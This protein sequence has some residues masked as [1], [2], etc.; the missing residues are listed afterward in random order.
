MVK[1]KLKI[2]SL[3]ALFSSTVMGEVLTLQNAEQKAVENAFEIRATEKEMESKEWEQ[4]NVFT[5]Y[6]PTV[7]YNMA[8]VRMDQDT[9]DKAL[10]ASGGGL[11]TVNL[12][13]YSHEIAVKQPITNGGAEI[14]AINIAKH[15]KKAFIHERDA[16]IQSVILNTRNMYFRLINAKQ[17]LKIS[18]QSLE[19]NKQKYKETQAR[20]EMGLLPET[21]VLRW[22]SEVVTSEKDVS[23]ATN[24]VRVLALQLY[25]TMG[26]AM[27]DVPN[28]IIVDQFKYFE[29]RFYGT[30]LQE[31]NYLDNPQ[32]KSI[33]EYTEVSRGYKDLTTS[34]FLPKVNAFFNYSWPASDEITPDF[35]NEGWTTGVTAS[36]PLFHS[37]KNYTKRQQALSEYSKSQIDEAKAKNNLKINSE[38]LKLD[39]E[40][41]KKNVESSKS[42]M[43]LMT[44]QKEMMD[45]RY[46]EGLTT[47]LELMEISVSSQRAEM[48]YVSELLTALSLEAEYLISIGK[49]EVIK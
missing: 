35:D 20:K 24:N 41:A 37:F 33:E 4:K 31:G 42:L 43:I 34:N 48:S 23:M 9:Y 18:T 39:F 14:Y 49:L 12:N 2:V 7:D 32:L 22:Y 5:N 16:Q 1:T 30:T 21:E 17:Y 45:Q 46:K 47:Q 26:I 25:A 10:V 44:R 27:D 40:T 38:R 19:W 3:I 13:S 28:E 8:Y 29:D 11:S 6:L 15:S 36:V